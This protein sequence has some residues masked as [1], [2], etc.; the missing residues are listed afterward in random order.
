[1]MVWTA[2]A[3]YKPYFLFLIAMYGTWLIAD[4]GSY[5]VWDV[6]LLIVC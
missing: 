3:R 6:R 1:M 2:S 5:N 4:Y